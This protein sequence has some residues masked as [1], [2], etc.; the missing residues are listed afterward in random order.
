MDNNK[1]ET[2]QS[3]KSAARTAT[4]KPCWRLCKRGSRSGTARLDGDKLFA[5]SVELL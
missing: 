1:A 3:S 4:V 5:V 2:A